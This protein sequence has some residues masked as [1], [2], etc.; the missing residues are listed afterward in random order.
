MLW[1]LVGC[2]GVLIVGCAAGSLWNLNDVLWIVPICCG[3]A[4]CLWDAAVNVG[5]C[6]YMVECVGMFYIG[7]VAVFCRMCRYIVECAGVL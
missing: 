2:A 5:M 3:M 6:R 1:Y 7:S 4:G